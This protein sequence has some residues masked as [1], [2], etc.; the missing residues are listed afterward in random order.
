MSEETRQPLWE[1]WRNVIAAIAAVA[2]MMGVAAQ[3]FFNIGTSN[4][5]AQNINNSSSQIDCSVQVKD[6]SRDS[7][8]SV[9]IGGSVCDK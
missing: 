7:S 2:A 8:I 1:N 3:A 4:H 6:V 5:D 9:S